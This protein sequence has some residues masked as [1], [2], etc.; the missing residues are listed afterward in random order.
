[1]HL[2]DDLRLLGLAPHPEGGFFRETHRSAQCTVIDFVLLSGQVSRWHRVHGAEEVWLHHRGAPL[3][4][5]L[6]HADGTHERI[7]I[8]EERSTAVVPAGCWQAAE[9]LV[10]H[11]PVDYCW[12]SCVVSPPFTFDRFELGS[13]RG[14][15]VDGL[16]R[17][18]TR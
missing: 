11:S 10:D 3:A 16:E 5:H 7:R 8:D 4:L 15:H 13:A 18:S 2:P 6:L 17:F 12:V 9:P 14:P 1:M